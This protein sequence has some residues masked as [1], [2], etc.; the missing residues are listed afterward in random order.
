MDWERYDLIKC[1]WNYNL[2]EA[3]LAATQGLPSYRSRHLPRHVTSY[4]LRLSLSRTAALPSLTNLQAA[5]NI[6]LRKKY[7]RMLAQKIWFVFYTHDLLTP[8]PAPRTDWVKHYDTARQLFWQ[9]AQ[10]LS[11]PWSIMKPRLCQPASYIRVFASCCMCWHSFLG[12]KSWVGPDRFGCPSLLHRSGHSS[13]TKRMMDA[14][15]KDVVRCRLQIAEVEFDLTDCQAGVKKWAEFRAK[16]Q[17]LCSQGEIW[18]WT[19]KLPFDEFDMWSLVR[20][21]SDSLLRTDNDWV[22]QEGKL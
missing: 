17:I 10:G 20:I 19:H 8:S 18:C 21:N 13:R 1:R 11:A 6:W 12:I 5:C 3:L 2:Q 4:L 15:C 7:V 14:S 9:M 16:L 22:A